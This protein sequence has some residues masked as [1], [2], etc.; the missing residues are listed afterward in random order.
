MAAGCLRATPFEHH[1]GII[2]LTHFRYG[3]Q[4]AGRSHPRRVALSPLENSLFYTCLKAKD[5]AS[6]TPAHP[7][8]DPISLSARCSL[9]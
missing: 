9:N 7:L 6:V 3:R 4:T 1:P 5:A 8:A 2:G